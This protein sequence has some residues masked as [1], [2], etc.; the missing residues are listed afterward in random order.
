[1]ENDLFLTF[2]NSFIE[3]NLPKGWKF[4]KVSKLPAI[5]KISLKCLKKEIGRNDN[6]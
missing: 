6:G 4:G 3:R 5:R 1:M 2:R